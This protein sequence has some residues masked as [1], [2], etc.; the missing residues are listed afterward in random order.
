MEKKELFITDIT[1]QKKKKDRYNIY[2]DGEYT[3][4]LG[5]SVC[6]VHHI[7]KG[8]TIDEDTFRAAI[9]EDNTQ[10]AFDSALHLLAHKMRTRAELIKRLAGKGIGDDAISAALDKLAAYGYVDDG[11]YAKEYIESA[12][13]AAK[14][15]R[16]AVMYK[17]KEKGLG[18]DVIADALLAYTDEL[19]KDIAEQNIS[20]L[21]RR[22]QNDD[23]KKRR[24]KIFAALARHGFD[25]DII[26]TILNKDDSQ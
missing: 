2:I 26:N 7:K 20:K 14:L 4:S 22:Y 10:Y 17:L 12:I 13:N 11:Q 1:P 21:V 15:G 18:D 23:A 16:K 19:E 25:Y 6:A 24:Q 9:F 5:A 3:A 8:E